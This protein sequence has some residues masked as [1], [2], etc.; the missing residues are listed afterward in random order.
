MNTRRAVGGVVGLAILLGVAY[1]VRPWLQWLVYGL[2]TTPIAWVFVPV[3]L[4]AVAYF[5]VSFE[6]R[7]ANRPLG[8]ALGLVV[9]A[10]IVLT[11][12]GGLY[13][14]TTLADRTMAGATPTQG[15]SPADAD[16]PR[17]VTRNVSDNYAANTLQLSR[18][19]VSNPDVTFR[20]GTPYW[21][22]ALS[23]DGVRNHFALKQ[24]GT[25]L[26]NMSAQNAKVETVRGELDAGIGTAW[27]NNY[28][29]SVLK[30]GQYLVDYGDPF[31]VPH[32]N[33]SYIA[34]P[35]TKPSFHVRAL[36]VPLPYTVPEW[37]G[38]AL[39]APDGSVTDLSPA[40]ARSNPVLRGQKLVPFDLT[41][42]RVTATKYRNGIL[43]TLPVVGSHTDE[44]EV[45][46]TPGSGNEQPYL[47]PTADGTKYVVAVE[48]F[49]NAQGLREVW[50]IDGRTGEASVYRSP[51]GESLFG[52][53]KAADY[54][55]QASRTT[56]W[57][58]FSPAEPLPVAVD[59]RLY[60]MVKVVPEGG[61]GISYVAFV[62]AESSNVQ[63]T[64]STAAVEEFLRGN[65][66]AAQSVRDGGPN[67]S[68]G[69]PRNETVAG[70]NV[71]LVVEKRAPNGSVV[72]TMTVYENESVSIEPARNGTNATAT[73]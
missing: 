3:G 26:V 20:N 43:N 30:Q 1:V 31:M 25:V 46:A 51:S 13:A 60:W 69:G 29:W 56:D 40:E 10:V 2:Y 59:D 34:V 48:P 19:R 67:A 27:Y 70:G 68:T 32:R 9:V 61:S 47:V 24:D 50:E 38:V 16:H 73:E 52:P 17:V 14:Q 39:V 44:I 41:R 35:Y 22:Y 33:E 21:S 15:L 28:R 37:G 18:Y 71:S 42:E 57:N 5:G 63:E 58:R 7:G 64:A 55:R 45:A 36:P 65:R 53:R 4:A 54:V 72:A 23:P 11:S 6:S 66:S 12:V 8:I 62:N 49:G